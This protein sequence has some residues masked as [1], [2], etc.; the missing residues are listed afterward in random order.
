M[1]PKEP[2]MGMP[3]QLRGCKNYMAWT[4]DDFRTVYAF[5]SDMKAALDNLDTLLECRELLKKECNDASEAL[6]RIVDS[7]CG[8][9][10]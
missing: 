9:K 1:L 5:L 8:E 4:D 3:G 2:F 10:S 7:L 6:G